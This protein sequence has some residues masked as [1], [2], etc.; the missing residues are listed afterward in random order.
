MNA[1]NG[2]EQPRVEWDCGTRG[3]GVLVSDSLMFER[4]APEPSDAHLSHFYGLALPLLKRGL[5]VTPVPLENLAV[6]HYLDG[7]RV[8]LLSYQG[9][10]PLSAEVHA[11]LARWVEDGG[12]L[13]VVDDDGDP[14]N[15]VRE[16]WN[17][18]GSNYATPRQHLFE[19]LGLTEQH[20]VTTGKPVKVGQG[21]VL[22]QR[23]NPA[24]LATE[25][26][27]DA[28]LRDAVKA[29]AA[30]I[31]I[32]WQEAN[33]LL[34]RRG[35]YLVAAGLDESR[36]GAP[37]VLSGR[38][39][40]LFDPEL[41]V[42]T[43]VTLAPGARFFLLDL[44]AAGGPEPQVLASACKALSTQHDWKALTLA[45]EGVAGTPGV[46]LLHTPLPPRTVTLAGQPSKDYE[47]SAADQLLW[48]RFPNEA[49]PRELRLTF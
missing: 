39:V 27:G 10:K 20:I 5:P 12:A 28:R 38:F 44:E 33:R 45:V 49:H 41:R 29:A 43:R 4:G 16:W 30:A 23:D 46:V 2:L 14:F 9:M 7:F 31:G 17:S 24:R 35:P 26:D 40:N 3:V 13:V 21:V 8:L 32:K 22:W 37:K 15:G 25:T 19:Q 48:I 36:P 11:P 18:A 6:P 47:Y 42:L 1:L 34:L